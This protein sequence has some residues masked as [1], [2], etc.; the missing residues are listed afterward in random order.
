MP[1]SKSISNEI[2]LLDSFH[3]AK[4]FSPEAAATKVKWAWLLPALVAELGMNHTIQFL[5]VLQKQK[6]WAQVKFHSDFKGKPRRPGKEPLL[7][8][9]IA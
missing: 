5:L 4:P 8:E 6:L 2:V 3:S 1:C 7:E 9:D